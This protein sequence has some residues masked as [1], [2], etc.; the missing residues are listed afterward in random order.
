[1][2]DFHTF[3]EIKS[4]QAQGLSAGQIARQLLRNRKTVKA[5]MKRERFRARQAAPGRAGKMEPYK[6]TIRFL[7]A[8]CGSY[9]AQQ[10]F[11]RLRE[12]GY[13]GGYTAVKEYV[14]EVRPRDRSLLLELTFAPGEAAQ[15]DFG[16]CGLTLVGNSRRRLSVF[17][18]V[19]CYS[20]LMYVEFL[21]RQTLE[22]FLA[23]HRHAF[24][25]FGGV[26]GY[27]IVDRA[28]VAI[29]GEDRFGK[30][31][32]NPRYADLARHYGFDIRACAK[33]MAR[34]KGRVENGI[35]YVKGNFMNGRQ[36][37][38]FLL[39]CE[40]G[41]RWVEEIANQR[42]HRTTREK[43]VVLFEREKPALKPLPMHPYDCSV[44]HTVLVNRQ[45]RFHFDG[46]RY[47]VPPQ[48]A[49]G[50]LLVR[51]LPEDL[52]VYA[53]ETLVARHQRCYE[54]RSEPIVDP[55]HQLALDRQRR[56]SAERKLIQR[57]LA[58]GAPGCAYYEGLQA[59]QVKP[60]S[61]VRKILALLEIHGRDKLLCALQDAGANQAFSAEYI[62]NLLQFRTHLQP[63]SP[64]RLA[65]RQ[66]LLQ[67][68]LEEPTLDQYQRK[69][70]PTPTEE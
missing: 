38:P 5:W 55:E 28:K 44:E 8:E 24:E 50:K 11:Q 57:F 61:H 25:A 52:C 51:A 43:P 68:E 42:I 59:R 32:P 35:G 45:A 40:E 36:P 20:R 2:I 66:D 4:L 67:I 46:N 15:V 3:N 7:L 31:I 47:S 62:A 19:L 14:R 10:I 58:L 30:P 12:E 22:C 18:M 37:G 54:R 13:P 29:V 34:E 60:L 9:S 70:D 56:H 16:D 33:G 6:R 49:P 17:V 64:L 21:L 53:G 39:T 69:I 27:V 1:M 26:V 48:Y 65:R 63:P 23:C 41:K